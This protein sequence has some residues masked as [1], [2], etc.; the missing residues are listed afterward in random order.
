[1]CLSTMML[2]KA[3]MDLSLTLT[4]ANGFVSEW[5]LHGIGVIRISLI[6]AVE[7]FI[8]RR[9]GIYGFSIIYKMGMNL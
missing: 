8:V 1:M 2:L 3:R 7:D 5:R 6:E 9:I 4:L